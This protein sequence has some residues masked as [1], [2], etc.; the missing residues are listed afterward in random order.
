M[1]RKLQG[2]LD[3]FVAVVESDWA[4]RNTGSTGASLSPELVAAAARQGLEG[5]SGP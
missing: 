1:R 5:L 3:E 2:M 4:E